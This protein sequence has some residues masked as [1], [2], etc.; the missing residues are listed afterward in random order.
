MLQQHSAH[1][2]FHICL[3]YAKLTYHGHPLHALK[4]KADAPEKKTYR[5]PVDAVTSSV[6]RQIVEHYLSCTHG[7]ADE[8]LSSWLTYNGTVQEMVA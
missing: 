5:Q 6:N 3:Q 1:S 4:E 2:C 8:R 7:S